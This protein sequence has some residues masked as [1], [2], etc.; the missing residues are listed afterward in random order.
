[1]VINWFLKNEITYFIKL[2][3]Y[4]KFLKKTWD[5]KELFVLKL[6]SDVFQY[7]L[8][9]WYSCIVPKFTKSLESLFYC[10]NKNQNAFFE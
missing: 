3:K 8:I 7:H 10:Q 5:H 1:M 9:L 6:K 2:G 4:L